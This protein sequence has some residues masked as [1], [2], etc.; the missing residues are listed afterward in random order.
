[1]VDA[2]AFV[3]EEETVELGVDFVA[4]LVDAEDDGSLLVF[5]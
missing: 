1:L 2:G 4:G 5:C 3:E